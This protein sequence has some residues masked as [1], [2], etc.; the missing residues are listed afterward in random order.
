MARLNLEYSMEAFHKV[1]HTL[2]HMAQQEY[3]QIQ[4]YVC[5]SLVCEYL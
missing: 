1:K 4:T 5:R 2:Y 3:G